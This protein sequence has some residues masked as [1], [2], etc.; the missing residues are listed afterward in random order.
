MHQM[1]ITC[2]GTLLIIYIISSL[3]KER[4]YSKSILL[5][6]ELF[7]TSSSFN[8][9]AFLVLLITAFLYTFF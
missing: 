2:L 7:R 6:K 3:E 5:S 8:I 9:S 4:D 1:L